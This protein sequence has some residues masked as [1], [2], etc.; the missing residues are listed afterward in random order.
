MSPAHCN[1]SEVRGLDF[2]IEPCW[3][4]IPF[5]FQAPYDYAGKP[6]KFYMVVEASGS[7]KPENI[8][9]M[10]VNVLKKKLS[11]LQT[12]LS[13]ELQNDALTIN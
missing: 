13:H 4:L 12:Q 1:E 3:I 5:I 10:G 6:N 11:D 9:I 2:D 7:L 8:P